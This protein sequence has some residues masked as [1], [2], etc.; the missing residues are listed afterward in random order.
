MRFVFGREV[1]SGTTK[2]TLE[3]LGIFDGA[4]LQVTDCEFESLNGKSHCRH[5]HSNSSIDEADWVEGKNL[6]S[7]KGNKN[8][9]F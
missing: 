8:L 1:I 5:G 6:K 9:K 7:L 2:N 3:E 4:T